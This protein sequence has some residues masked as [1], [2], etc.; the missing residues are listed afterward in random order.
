MTI[1]FAEPQADLESML[2]AIG[3][4]EK[5]RSQRKKEKL[6]LKKQMD[7]QE[8]MQK[9]GQMQTTT[10]T[11]VSAPSATLTTATSACSTASTATSTCGASKMNSAGVNMS[12]NHK[13]GGNACTKMARAPRNSI[14]EEDLTSLIPDLKA[15]KSQRTKEQCGRG[16][17]RYFH[18]DDDETR[19]PSSSSSTSSSAS[20]GKTTSSSCTTCSSPTTTSNN[21]LITGTSAS[22]SSSS[23]SFAT[24][25]RPTAIQSDFHD[26]VSLLELAEIPRATLASRQSSVIDPEKDLLDE[27]RSSPHGAMAATSVVFRKFDGAIKPTEIVEQIWEAELQR[28]A[29]VARAASEEEDMTLP[30]PSQNLLPSETTQQDATSKTPKGAST[31]GGTIKSTKEKAKEIKV[32]FHS[33]VR[34]NVPQATAEMQ[35]LVDQ[36]K[37]LFAEEFEEEFASQVSKKG[38]Y[39]LTLMADEAGDLCSFIMYK[40]NPSEKCLSIA[41]VAVPSTKRRLGYGR[42]I[43]RWL[44]QY[45]K[46]Q[47]RSQIAFLALSSMPGSIK[48]H[49]SLG[50]KKSGDKLTKKEDEPVKE[51][52]IE[53]AEGQVYMTYPIKGGK[54]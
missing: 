29:S 39:R 9:Q 50:F 30:L 23:S 44:I 11:M 47:P 6:R 17:S 10:S 53:Y 14:T 4:E 18:A 41:H 31:P 24:R 7:Q 26:Q 20:C 5:T 38:G 35:K 34:A 42:R 43:M 33:E 16:L 40:T 19:S 54:R 13:Y 22:S 49:Q 2:L 8:L 36:A 32:T 51:G 46:K 25:P 12:M 48:F 28:R 27:L 37:D 1:A 21:V 15:Q 45:A 52:E 3:G